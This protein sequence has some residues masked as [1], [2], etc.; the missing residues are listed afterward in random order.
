MPNYDFKLGEWFKQVEKKEKELKAK[1]GPGSDMPENEQISAVDNSTARSGP[2]IR[3]IEV[4]APAAAA[5]PSVVATIDTME[6]AAD[7]RLV[8]HDKSDSQPDLPPAHRRGIDPSVFSGADVPDVED[9]FSFLSRPREVPPT[10]LVQDEPKQDAPEQPKPGFARPEPLKPGRPE[11]QENRS[12]IPGGVS[13]GTGEPRPIVRDAQPEVKPVIRQEV[14]TQPVVT[15]QPRVEP[16]PIVRV[17]PEVE[18]K[19]EPV[20]QPKPVAKPKPAAVKIV[21][22]VEDESDVQANWDR[23]PHHLQTLFSS[24]DAEIAQNSYK[25]FKET[26][27]ELIQRLLDPVISLEEAARVLNVCPT[28]VRRYTNRGVLRHIRTAGNQRR[29]RLSDVLVFME[30]GSRRSAAV[31]EPKNANG[32]DD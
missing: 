16:T 9:F 1:K 31:S 8:D 24:V 3:N 32:A 14:I 2:E 4:E 5:S 17:E 20:V 27:G 23:V 19:A 26:R 22:P 25:T 28:T 11:I 12:A 30:S 10:D 13:E 15:P 29:F 7:T 21:Q 18:A 6:I